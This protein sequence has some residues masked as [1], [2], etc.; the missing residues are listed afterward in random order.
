M[1]S[2]LNYVHRNVNFNWSLHL[3]TMYFKDS[4]CR[5][6]WPFQVLTNLASLPWDFLFWPL[7][8][9]RETIL[10]IKRYHTTNRLHL[11][12]VISNLI[13][14]FADLIKLCSI[15][16]SSLDK[17]N[18]VYLKRNRTISIILYVIIVNVLQNIL[19][20]HLYMMTAILMF[21][22]G[23]WY[24]IFSNAVCKLYVISHLYEMNTECLQ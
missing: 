14:T 23:V 2:E 17:I 8:F 9:S 7:P 12:S 5:I 24:V 21:S 20:D 1:K 18:R 6:V 13:P 4:T 16:R 3:S 10:V 11:M 15:L 19:L 22:I